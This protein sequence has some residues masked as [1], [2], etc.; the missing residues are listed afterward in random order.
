[1]LNIK[2]EFL[3]GN[4]I[5]KNLNFHW[6]PL[7][8]QHQVDILSEKIMQTLTTED[9]Y[10]KFRESFGSEAQTVFTKNDYELMRGFLKNYGK[11]LD[12]KLLQLHVI[13][14]YNN[15]EIPVEAVLFK[16]SLKFEKQELDLNV[17]FVKEN[18]KILIQ[19]FRASQPIQK[20]YLGNL[21]D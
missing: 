2:V 8:Q 21:N 7:K 6:V 3:D 4:T 20:I 10:I 9:N 15:E 18:G 14:Q 19:S 12:K 1:M 16:Y 11:Y 5:V 13:W 17:S